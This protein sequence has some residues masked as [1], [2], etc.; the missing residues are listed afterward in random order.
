MFAIPW[1]LQWIA[2]A[3]ALCL[4]LCGIACILTALIRQPRFEIVPANEKDM[5]RRVRKLQ[6]QYLKEYEEEVKNNYDEFE[7]AFQRELQLRKEI[8]AKLRAQEQGGQKGAAAADGDV[9]GSE[10]DTVSTLASV[11]VPPSEH[12]SP[13]GG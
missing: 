7:A 12:E 9:N 3:G 8:I 13:S 5:R 1:P 2:L 11:S 4:W 10:T 6:A